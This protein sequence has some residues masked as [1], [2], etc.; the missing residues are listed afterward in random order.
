MAAT[1]Q[2]LSVFSFI[3]GVQLAALISAPIVAHADTTGLLKA[4]ANGSAESRYAAIDDLGERHESPES[5]VPALA[6]LLK[7]SDAKVRWRSARSLGDYGPQAQ[8]AVSK[9]RALLTDKDPIVQHHA[10]IALGKIGDRSD[11]TIDA[12]VKTVTVPD[13]RV[14]RAA[15][16][17]LRHLNPDPQH[18]MAVLDQMLLSEDHVIAAHALE[19]AVERGAKAVPMLNAA[20]KRPKTAYLACAAIEQIGP[21]AAETVPALTELLGDTKHSQLLIQALLALASIGPKAQSASPQIVDLLEHQTDATVPVAAAYA[22]GAIGA[23]DADQALRNAASKPNP[24]LQMVA[25]WSLAKVHPDDPALQQQAM[26]K[27]QAGIKSKDP[28][29]QAAAEHGMKLLESPV[30]QAAAK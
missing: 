5:V 22:L 2:R 27:L 30:K 19:A 7:D 12:L 10:A 28:A 21:E 18:V 4:A 3:T 16:V 24:F 9:V 15:I 26:Q 20:L 17:A 1:T 29:I 8:P 25:A 13:G 14:A 6:N 23:A 11:E